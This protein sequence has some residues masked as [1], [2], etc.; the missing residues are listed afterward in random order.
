[1]SNC[2]DNVNKYSNNIKV[3]NVRNNKFITFVSFC[4]AFL[5]R[6]S[7]SKNMQFV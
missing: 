4:H 2:K 7:Y 1:M 5:I 3:A 6:M